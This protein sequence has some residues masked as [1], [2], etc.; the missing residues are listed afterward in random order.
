VHLL[1]DMTRLAQLVGVLAS[2]GLGLAACSS[3]VV[4]GDLEGGGGDGVEDGNGGDGG[5]GGAP[6]Q[7]TTTSSNPPPPSP[8]ISMLRWEL[9]N[10]PAPSGVSVS[11][12]GGNF[13]TVGVTTGSD[14]T[15]S[16]VTTGSS[17]LDPYD[18]VIILGS[19]LQS[20]SD[21]FAN[22]CS[23]ASWRVVISLPTPMQAQGTYA[24]TGLANFSE[25][26]S[27]ESG[28]GGSYWEGTITVTHIDA[29]QVDFVLDGT[30][31]FFFQNGNADGSYSAP[32]CF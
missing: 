19:Q 17:S 10:P 15:T 16:S 2:L 25:I 23:A 1:I 27:C 18:L 26:T 8:A 28:G 7:P 14:P 11:T 20:C 22:D 13:T 29:G 5:N 24:L 32:R 31:D 9:D 4:G 30:S 21:P 6:N 12:T 3:T